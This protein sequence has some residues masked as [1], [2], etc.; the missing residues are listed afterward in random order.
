MKKKYT[1]NLD[2]DSLSDYSLMVIRKS[3]VSFSKPIQP[4][5]DVVTAVGVKRGLLTY[6]HDTLCWTPKALKIWRQAAKQRSDRQLEHRQAEQFF[7]SSKTVAAMGKKRKK[8]VEYTGVG[9]DYAKEF[10]KK[11][12]R[13]EFGDHYKG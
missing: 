5:L 7:V 11:A 1:Y 8:K 6:E 9:A 13:E 10:G 12:A 2:V 3:V 4:F